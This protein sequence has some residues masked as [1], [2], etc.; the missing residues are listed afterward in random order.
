MRPS[1]FNTVVN[2][3][4]KLELSPETVVSLERSYRS[5]SSLMNADAST[6]QETGHLSREDVAGLTGVE[7]WSDS[8]PNII[9]QYSLEYCCPDGC[10]LRL[11]RLAGS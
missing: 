1:R 2:A 10:D 6:H 8:Y 7:S 4:S 11:S 5:W 9:Q 3:H